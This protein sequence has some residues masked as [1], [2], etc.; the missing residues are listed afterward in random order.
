MPERIIL[1]VLSCLG[2]FISIYF[3]LVYNKLVKPNAYWLPKFCRLEDGACESILYT[4]DA[5]IFKVP[6]F[7]LGILFY[8]F[9]LIVALDETLFK[10][11][12]IGVVAATGFTV[13]V[14]IYLMYSLLF[15][16]RVNCL[17]CF[18]SHAINLVLFITMLIAR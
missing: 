14:G 9:M 18:I 6:N 3:T 16:I 8:I 2:L 10:A 13:V 11:L 15:K 4:G 17:L 1:T 12:Y 7:Y 5:H